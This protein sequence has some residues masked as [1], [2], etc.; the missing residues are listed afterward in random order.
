MANE[1]VLKLRLDV[2]YD[3]IVADINGIEKGTICKISG[4]G[5]AHASEAADT[6]VPFAGVARREKITIDGRTRLSL[7]R[8]GIFDMVDAGSGITQG[9]WVTISG[10]NLIRT[11]TAAEVATGDGIGT[12][13]ETIAG[14]GTGEIILGGS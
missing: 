13:R 8:R 9:E 6:G 7:F 10:V 12:A 2:P 11:A 3:W 1:A 4:V 5:T 14:G